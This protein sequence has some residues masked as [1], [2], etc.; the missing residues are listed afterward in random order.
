MGQ[1]QPELDQREGVSSA[2]RN[3]TLDF[4]WDELRGMLCDE[5]PCLLAAQASKSQVG[6]ARSGETWVCV[7]HR[8]EDEDAFALDTTCGECQRLGRLVVEPMRVVYHTEDRLLL[9]RQRE[10]P[11]RCS[12][13]GEAIDTIRLL[14]RE[15]GLQRFALRRR[16][17]LQQ[18]GD[19]AQEL[20]E[21][22]E[23]QLTF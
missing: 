1:D 9:S 16:Q 6:N 3:Q 19:W 17:F 12:T 18:S 11:Q 22:R 20:V 14:Q 7:P 2:E 4:R 10:Q 13:D 21:R 8:E 15:C 5:P 23:R